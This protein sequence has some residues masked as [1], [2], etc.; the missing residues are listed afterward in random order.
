[1]PNWCNNVITFSGSDLDKFRETLSHAQD[2]IVFSF[3]QT[4]PNVTNE[5]LYIWRMK[6]WGCKFDADD[7]KVTDKGDTIVIDCST[8]NVQPIQWAVNCAKKFLGLKISIKYDEPG[9]GLTE[10]VL[11]LLVK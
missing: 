2:E 7:V 9:L 4:V 6:N 3:D 10:Q 1:M 11:I 8:P 5:S